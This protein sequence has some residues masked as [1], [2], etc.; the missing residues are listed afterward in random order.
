MIDVTKPLS[1]FSV[2]IQQMV[3]IARAVDIFV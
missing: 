1:N 2:A 3:A